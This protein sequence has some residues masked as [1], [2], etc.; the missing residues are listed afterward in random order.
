MVFIRVRAGVYQTE[1]GLSIIHDKGD[2]LWYIVYKG[3]AL[4]RCPTF[5]DAKYICTKH[6]RNKSYAEHTMNMRI[7][8]GVLL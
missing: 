3:V 1:N 7:Q 8:K 5:T 2:K 4:H 6:Y